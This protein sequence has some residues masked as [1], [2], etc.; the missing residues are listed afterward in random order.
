[1]TMPKKLRQATLLVAGVATAALISAAPVQAGSVENLERERA[2]MLQAILTPDMSPDERQ[3]KITMSQRRL[4]DLERIVLRDDNLTDRA[5]PAV[6]TAFQNYDLTFLVHAA[7]EKNMLVVDN[8]F[9]AMGLT[10]QSLMATEV[11]PE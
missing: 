8:W 6:R 10:T 5:T 9:N 3:S 7:T 1:M 4:V 2:M 11:G